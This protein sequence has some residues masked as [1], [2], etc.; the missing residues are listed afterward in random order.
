MLEAIESPFGQKCYLCLRAGGMNTNITGDS[1][2]YL[3]NSEGVMALLALKRL[4]TSEENVLPVTGGNATTAW[5]VVGG[6]RE[7]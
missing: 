1:L 3:R 7:H 6:R 4:V 5:P 2:L